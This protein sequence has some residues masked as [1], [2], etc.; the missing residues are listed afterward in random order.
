MTMG[1]PRR[2]DLP[3]LFRPVLQIPQFSLYPSLLIR[4]QPNA[5]ASVTAGVRQI[6]AEGG[7]EF[8]L[9]AN[10]LQD[11]LDR[12][13]ASERMS[14]TIAVTLAALAIVLSFVG[15]FGVL[16]YSVSRR[17]RE[18]GVRA[19]VGADA[20]SLLWMVMREGAVLTGLG[21]IAGVPLAYAAAEVLGSLTFGIS[22][23]DP[24]T[25]GLTSV[26]FL[27][28]GLAAGLVPARRAAGV[29][30]VIALRAE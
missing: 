6:A 9:E 30:P 23:G 17:T 26:F 3:M 12:A 20:S 8:L 22:R 14:A 21:V 5:I 16:A 19:A 1:N 18:I 4:H 15:V 10:P 11:L 24:I 27:V 25:F 2:T 28:L 29:D 13:P 7:R